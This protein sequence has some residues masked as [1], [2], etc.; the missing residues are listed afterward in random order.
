MV[1]LGI[2]KKTL[3]TIIMVL[4]AIVSAPRMAAQAQA[5]EESYKFDIGVGLGMAGYLGDMNESNLFRHPGVAVNGSFRYLANTRWAIRG[6]ISAASLSGNSADWENV[7]PGGAAYDFKAW[8]S[9]FGVRAEFNFFNYGIGESYKQMK[10]L[11]PYAALGAGMSLSGVD[12]GTY[13]AVNLPIAVGLKFK[14]RPR[15][16][17][18][19]EFTM[20]KVLGDRLD[21]LKDPYGIESSM[22]KNTDWYGS[23]AVSISYEFGQR[24]V[25]CHRI[26]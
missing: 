8:V 26:D 25:V 4:A 18:G 7:M 15:L 1:T 3:L 17:L 14:L 2:M 11:T 9:D 12:G 16:N 5:Q 20:T 23:L 22:L 6:I 10:R 19:L 24:C 13:V 21:G